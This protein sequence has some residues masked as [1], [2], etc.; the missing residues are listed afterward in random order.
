M[1]YCLL[2]DLVQG[3]YSENVMC[4]YD[5][6]FCDLH[7]IILGSAVIDGECGDNI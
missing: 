7:S 1:I 5:I 3:M 2:I 6:F 4:D